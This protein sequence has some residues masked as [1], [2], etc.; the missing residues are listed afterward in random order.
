M[1]FKYINPK[2]T[3]NTASLPKIKL[4]GIFKVA[5]EIQL[6][7]YK[8]TSMKFSVHLSGILADQKGER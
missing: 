7:A 3:H 2:G 5:R 6:V 1:L 8:E 4:K